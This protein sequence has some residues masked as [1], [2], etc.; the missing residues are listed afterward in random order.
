MF[1]SCALVLISG[2]SALG[3]VRTEKKVYI[4]NEDVLVA[5][6][7]LPG[8][9]QDWITIVP[10]RYS[11][12]QI[13]EWYFTKG[14]RSGTMR[15]I[16]DLA[17][18]DYVVRVYHNWPHGGHIVREFATFRVDPTTMPDY[19][20]VNVFPEPRWNGYPI[21][22]CLDYYNYHGHGCGK[23]AADWFCREK[24]FDSSIRHFSSGGFPDLFFVIDRKVCLEGKCGDQAYT[25]ITCMDDYFEPRFWGAIAYGE[26]TGAWGRSWKHKTQAEAEKR[27]LFE[28]SRA[29]GEAC[30]VVIPYPRCGA[31]AK[32]GDG[33]W[34]SAKRDDISAAKNAALERC[35]RIASG[36][37]LLTYGCAGS[38]ATGT[39]VR[40]HVEPGPKWVVYYLSDEYSC[41]AADTDDRSHL[42]PYARVGEKPRSIKFGKAGYIYDPDAIT[43]RGGFS[44]YEK[45]L[46]W[47]CGHRIAAN[48]TGIFNSARIG[49]ILI[50]PT[51]CETTGR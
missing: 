49:G 26:N 24:N 8:N 22:T 29:S 15:F 20:N 13:G 30:G 6:S 45:A 44:S 9:K 4:P 25:S 28:C 3:A 31:L 32:A 17:P 40:G 38:T 51:P 50:G 19:P 33:T 21:A 5:Y 35:N 36:C 41:C 18:G 46:D 48:P 2:L 37:N 12:D 34:A 14:N 39:M 42:Y 1:L 27:A 11:S 47:V 10:S 43:I 23:K 7:G 16:K